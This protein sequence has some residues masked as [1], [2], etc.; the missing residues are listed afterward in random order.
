MS[1]MPRTTTDENR[2]EYRILVR[3]VLAI[4]ATP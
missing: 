1:M 4:L 3:A 2:L